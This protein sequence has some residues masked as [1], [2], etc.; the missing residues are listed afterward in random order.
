ML[1]YYG[2]DWLDM[3]VFSSGPSL[4]WAVQRLFENTPDLSWSR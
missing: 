2:Q 1:F 4:I 3:V